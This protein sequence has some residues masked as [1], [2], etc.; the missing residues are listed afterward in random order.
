MKKF[1]EFLEIF[2]L[3]MILAF[4][5]MRQ[6]FA[7]GEAFKKPEVFIKAINPGYTIDGKANVG[8]MIEIS[9]LG[10]DELVS[11][12]GITISYI[13]SSGN[14]STLFEFPEYSF[15]SG[16][17]ILLRLASSPGGELAA[18]NYTKTLAFKGG[19]SLEFKGE[20]I[21]AVCWSGGE[22][23]YRE[24]KSSMPT[25]LVRN[26]ETLEFEH[27]DEYEPVF[28][29]ENYYV[30]ETEAEV[31]PSR[32]RGLE[33]S[34][35]LSYYE[36]SRDEQFIELYNSAAEQ[37]LLN[38]C[39]LKY[40]NKLYELSGVLRPEEYFIYSVKDFSLTKNPTNFNKL[41]LIDVNGEVVDILEY[42]NG[43]RKGTS[44]IFLGYDT[45]GKE[46][47]R[48]TYRPTP[49]E[50][51]HFQEFKSC[52]SG[53]VL[54]EITGNC[55]KV[56][57]LSEKV[58]GAGQYLNILTGRCRKIKEAA[59]K[60]C[61]EGYYLNLETGRCR[62]FV[63]NAGADYNLESENYEESSS[64][65]AFYAV[66]GVVV[67]GLGYLGFEF[68]TEILKLFDKVFRRFR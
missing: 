49:G 52:E 16:E 1:L 67:L 37:I 57:S 17:S 47:W 51:N 29:P 59:E 3:S 28:N 32:C 42:P 35:I 11:L 14:T 45:E 26:L 62:K 41:E 27:V 66:I 56:T 19:I 22:G 21:D 7:E 65:V 20:V 46:I 2:I 30:K 58:C 43:Q 53:K 50:A 9:R 60:T 4:L 8:E 44:Y 64:F 33:F 10:S 61:K 63:E 18:E 55:V 38:G 36:S 40:K 12:A 13:N 23:C 5:G 48:I 25:S 24:F 15:M 6:V 54:N 68:R 34:E 39:K 31:L